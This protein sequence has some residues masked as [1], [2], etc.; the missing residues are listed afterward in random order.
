[1]LSVCLGGGATL[2]WRACTIWDPAA[3]PMSFRRH[4]ELGLAAAMYT[5]PGL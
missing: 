5:R 1:M 3:L 4:S 2:T